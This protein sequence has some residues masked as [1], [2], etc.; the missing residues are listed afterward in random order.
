MNTR[1]LLSDTTSHIPPARALEELSAA[2]AER[3]V[4]GAS[5]SIAEIVAHLAFWQ[6]WFGRRARGT[7][8]PMPAKAAEGWPRVEPGSWNDI[9]MLF[10]S[11]LE[12]LAALGGGDAG[13]RAVSP[14]IEYLPLAHYSVHDAVV[15]I[16]L[17]NAH[18]LGQV[19]L[20]RQI[21]GC[22][23]PPREAGPGSFGS[24]S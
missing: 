14:A 10:L 2:D 18:H 4:P 8:R 16:A 12:P 23:P 11:G 19:V 15:H 24:L 13:T 17:H 9:K 21:I 6:D 22:W 5:H 1:E 3:R 7:G 20:L